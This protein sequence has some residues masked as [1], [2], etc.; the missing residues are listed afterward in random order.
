M[1]ITSLKDN[2]THQAQLPAIKQS[3][4]AVILGQE[5]LTVEQVV[6]VARY[7]TRAYISGEQQVLQRVESSSNYIAEAVANGQPIYETYFPNWLLKIIQ[8]CQ[9]V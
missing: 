6:Q 9:V 2:K 7:G 5:N 1:N 8:N 4:P 3:N